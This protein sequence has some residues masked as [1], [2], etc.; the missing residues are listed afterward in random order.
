MQKF[1]QIFREIWQERTY[2]RIHAILKCHLSCTCIHSKN[3]IF[4]YNL[5]IFTMPSHLFPPNHTLV[6]GFEAPYVPDPDSLI[7]TTTIGGLF[8]TNSI[9]NSLC[10]FPRTNSYGYRLATAY[11][12]EEKLCTNMVV[13]AQIESSKL[14]QLP[15]Y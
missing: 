5:Y 2:S 1:G 6:L 4:G 12:K 8:M 15:R 3:M 7:T 14:R 9:P 11:E 10:L 13:A